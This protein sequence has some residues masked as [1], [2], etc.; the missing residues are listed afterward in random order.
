MI[1]SKWIVDMKQVKLMNKI[2]AGSDGEV[3]QA[4][5]LGANVA[6]KF[7]W[8]MSSS[9]GTRED[10][11]ETKN[12]QTDFI[13][14][15]EIMKN[16]NHPNVIQVYGA[17]FDRGRLGMIMQ[18]CSRGSLYSLL[19]KNTQIP[20]SDRKRKHMSL[21]IA[22]GMQY[23]HHSGV[24]HRDLKSPNIVVN[25]HFEV[26]ITDFARS[27]QITSEASSVGK[28][29]FSRG[30]V[31]TVAWTAPEIL[32]W[33]HFTKAADV[34]SFAIILWELL[35]RKEPYPGH[36]PNEIAQNVISGIRPEIPANVSEDF[37]VLLEKCWHQDEKKRISF[38]EIVAS[39]PYWS[40]RPQSSETAHT[41]IQVE[42][43]L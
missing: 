41:P 30:K 28:D 37:V 9:V 34:Y 23:L 38:Q 6:V 10:Q 22:A 12:P 24:L 17:C 13:K 27:R 35:T 18:F 31:G 7:L 20:L 21:Y 1:P 4:E 8:P 16:L 29:S 39:E 42:E 25:E 14:E 5:W 15:L 19:H 43:D 26:Q 32:S 33:S 40:F 11:A 3:F 2:G 36:S